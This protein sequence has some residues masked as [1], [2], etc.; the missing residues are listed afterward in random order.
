VYIPV[1]DRIAQPKKFKITSRIAN[2]VLRFSGN[3]RCTVP[4]AL[5]QPFF[6]NTE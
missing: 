2:N 5:H 3:Q 1:G 6:G 4:D